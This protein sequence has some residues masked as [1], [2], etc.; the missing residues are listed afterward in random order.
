MAGARSQHQG[1]LPAPLPWRI[2]SLSASHQD[3]PLA[4]MGPQNV[5]DGAHPFFRGHRFR[6]QVLTLWGDGVSARNRRWLISETGKAE[7][8]EGILLPCI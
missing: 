6:Q 2:P 4:Q 8:S 7:R 5:P 3:A 1:Q